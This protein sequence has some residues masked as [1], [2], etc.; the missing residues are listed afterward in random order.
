V[1][2]KIRMLTCQSQYVHIYICIEFLLLVLFI[3]D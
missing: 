2:K 1:L 3:L